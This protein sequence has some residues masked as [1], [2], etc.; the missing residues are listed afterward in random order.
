MDRSELD[1]HRTPSTAPSLVETGIDGKSVEPGVEAVGISKL[2]EIPP[3][4]DQAILDRVACELR[5]P[6]DEAGRT[7]QPHDGCADEL[8]KGVMIA[9]PRA[10]HEPSLV[11]GRL[12]MLA[13]PRGGRSYGM[14][15]ASRER[16]L[17]AWVTSCADEER[18][19]T[20]RRPAGRRCAWAA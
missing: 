9:S 18:R 3:R 5:V 19:P 1:L 8:G 7:V 10:F 4:P 20:G 14:A 17:V 13:S 15:S 12:I 16:F 6:E 11:H 2:R